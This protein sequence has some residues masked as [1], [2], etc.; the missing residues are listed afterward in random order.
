[1]NPLKCLKQVVFVVLAFMIG[2]YAYPSLKRSG[3]SR[4]FRHAVRSY[5]KGKYSDAE[6]GFRIAAKDS[7]PEAYINLG[8]M[9]FRGIGVEKDYNKAEPWL[10]LAAEHGFPEAQ[11]CL[12]V[13]YIKGEGVERNE[14]EALHWFLVAAVKGLPD[15]AYNLG[16]MYEYGL[17]VQQDS[18]LSRMW[19]ERAPSFE[20]D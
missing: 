11:F 4:N 16:V 7:I 17:G 13:I 15:A 18:V 1:M 8:L 12:G 20:K 3:E 10:R 9:Y 19:Y 6:K 14:K 2:W 5:K